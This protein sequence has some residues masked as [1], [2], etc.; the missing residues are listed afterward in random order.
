[1]VL[2]ALGVGRRALSETRPALESEGSTT[3]TE[4]VVRLSR[5]NPEDMTMPRA[6]DEVAFKATQSSTQCTRSSSAMHSLMEQGPAFLL[7]SV[8]WVLLMCLIGGRVELMLRKDHEDQMPIPTRTIG[9]PS[10]G[11]QYHVL[12]GSPQNEIPPAEED[13]PPQPLP[14]RPTA[15]TPDSAQSEVTIKSEPMRPT[16]VPIP[17]RRSFLPDAHPTTSTTLSG[18][19]SQQ[20]PTTALSNFDATYTRSSPASSSPSVNIDPGLNVLVVDDDPLTR[21]LMKRIL[22]R[23]GC[24]VTTAENGEIALELI[25]GTNGATPSSEMSRNMEPIA[26]H[27]GKAGDEARMGGG[28]RMRESSASGSATTNP[29]GKYAVVFLDN[30]M[31]VL[32]GLK[33]ISRLRE[34]GRNDFVVG[35]T[36]T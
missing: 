9:D 35:V 6:V 4:K 32:S 36:G 30:Q 17:E 2:I 22:S 11:T 23:L 29:E 28:S 19:S 25:L 3:T 10:T 26:E 21:T 5:Q 16:F 13:A 24:N 8:V 14:T 27:Q 33:A 12:P 7:S 18:G 31:P 1:M 20:S 34:L 15:A